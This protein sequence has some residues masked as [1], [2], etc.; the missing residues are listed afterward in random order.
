MQIATDRPERHQRADR[1]CF[2]PGWPVERPMGAPVRRKGGP[3]GLSAVLSKIPRATAGVGNGSNNVSCLI[4]FRQR[5]DEDCFCN[6]MAPAKRSFASPAGVTRPP[7]AQGSPLKPSAP[8]LRREIHRFNEELKRKNFPGART[9]AIGRKLLCCEGSL[10]KADASGE[11]QVSVTNVAAFRR[12]WRRPSWGDLGQGVRPTAVGPSSFSGRA[13]ESWTAN[14]EIATRR[15]ARVAAT[16]RGASYSVELVALSRWRRLTK[17][18]SRPSFGLN[19][20]RFKE[21]RVLG[22]QRTP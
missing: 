12:G 11:A 21:S 1:E 18:R 3:R 17:G 5:A 9:M 7:P 19:Q 22:E 10:E 15:V 4:H 20:S 14:G 6:R 13:P 2:S 16:L 8:R